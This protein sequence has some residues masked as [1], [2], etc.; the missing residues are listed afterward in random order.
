MT[1]DEWYQYGLEHEYCG[2]AYC[3]SH[4]WPEMSAEEE[5]ELEDSGEVCITLTRLMPK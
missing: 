2:K 3:M 4:D 1:F 5:A